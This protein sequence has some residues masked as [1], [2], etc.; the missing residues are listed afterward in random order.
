MVAIIDE[1]TVVLEIFR[2]STLICFPNAPNVAPN[3][4]TE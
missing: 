3:G 1:T 4:A 2:S